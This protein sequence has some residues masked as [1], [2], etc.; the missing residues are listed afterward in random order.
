MFH[1]ICFPGTLI[2]LSGA[3]MSN[4][5]PSICF[6]SDDKVRLSDGLLTVDLSSHTNL[7]GRNMIT[8]RTS[9]AGTNINETDI[10]G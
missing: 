8:H 6:H 10:Q 7:T 3:F 5:N 9:P 2:H 1:D 4:E